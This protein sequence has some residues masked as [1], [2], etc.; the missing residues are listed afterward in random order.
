MIV[1]IQ[2]S[3]LFPLSCPIPFTK[4]LSRYLPPRVRHVR[5]LLFDM[6]VHQPGTSQPAYAIMLKIQSEEIDAHLKLGFAHT[7]A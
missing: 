3:L 5:I 7:E 1:A 6:K 2:R 4:E